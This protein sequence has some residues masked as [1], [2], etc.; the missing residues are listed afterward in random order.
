MPET[1]A[2]RRAVPAAAPPDQPAGRCGG[3]QQSRHRPPRH[4]APAAPARATVANTPR[5]QPQPVMRSAI[6]TLPGS[7][8]SAGSGEV[9]AAV[10][11]R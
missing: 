4:R 3:R 1:A 9:Q 7:I 5:R 10:A 2:A 6:T 8:A 11:G